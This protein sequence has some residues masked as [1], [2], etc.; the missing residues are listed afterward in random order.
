MELKKKSIWYSFYDRGVYQGTEPFFENTDNYQWVKNVESNWE[1]I[2]K[3]LQFFIESEQLKSYF[4]TT[5]VEKQNTWKTIS[6]KTWNA[7][8]NL[9]FYKNA[10]T[11]LSTLNK[12]PGLVSISFN[13]LEEDAQILPH[14]GDTNAIHRCHLGLIIPGTLPECGF[15]VGDENRA[16]EEGKLLMFTDAHLHTAW[17]KTNA[18]RYIL[19]FDVIKPEFIDRQKN[20]CAVILASLFLQKRAETFNFLYKIPLSVQSV[21]H[22]F[23]TKLVMVY[24]PVRNFVVELIN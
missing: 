5:T 12:I 15:K 23:L 4:N 22:R 1:E 16:W 10:K 17:N 7:K 11:T 21:I 14:C 3:E 2:K 13:M 6:F 9:P 20:I 19:L 8:T 24:L 18:K